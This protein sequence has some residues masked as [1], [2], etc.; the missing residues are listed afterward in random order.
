[1]TDPAGRT[2]LTDLT[3]WDGEQCPAADT[4]ILSGGRIEAVCE[5]STLQGSDARASIPLPGATAL[6]G[7]TDAHVHMVLD[8]QRS[9]PPA[10]GEDPDPA[11]MRQRAGEMVRAGITTARDLGGGAWHEVALRDAIDAGEVPGPRLLCAGQPITSPGGHCH[12]WG[13][14]AGDAAAIRGVLDRQRRHGVNLIKVM[15]TGGRFTRGSSP[16]L[17]QFDRA[18]LQGIVHHARDHGLPVAAHCHGT[19]GIEAA[20]RAG[21]HS[22]EH[23][24]WVGPA[25]W[26][27]DYRED[28]VGH[29]VRQGIWVSPTIHRGWQRMLPAGNATGARMGTALARMR[30]AGVPLMASTDAGIPGVLHHELPQALAVFAALAGLSAEEA[31]RSATSRSAAGLGLAGETGR[32][33]P[34]LAADVLIVQGDPLHDLTALCQPV[35]VWARGRMVRSP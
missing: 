3:I 33:A 32:L 27:S 21:V 6:P 5:R 25:G 8:P 14:E 34:G 18:T 7:L 30:R 29:M 11:A 26:A 31:L 1:M 23:C 2:I 4:L 20:A 10:P 19:A 35:A 12:F 9:A 15:A 16:E 17:P 13:G 28:V 24:S 22:I